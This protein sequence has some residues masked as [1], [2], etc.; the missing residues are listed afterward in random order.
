MVQLQS[1]SSSCLLQELVL[2][3][4]GHTGDVFVHKSSTKSQNGAGE[5]KL[6]ESWTKD[7]QI[8]ND[9]TW[10]APAERYLEVH[11]AGQLAKL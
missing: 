7:V 1:Q 11:P 2:A 3:L 8:A 5:H 6:L 9:L 10:V 4:S